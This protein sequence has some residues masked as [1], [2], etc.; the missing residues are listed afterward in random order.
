MPAEL[1]ICKDRAE[2]LERRKNYIGGSDASAVLG[3]NPWKT[4]VELWMEKTGQT[5]PEDISEKPYVKFGTQAEPLMRELFKLDFPELEVFYEENN[6]FLNDKYPWGHYSADGWIK[7]EAG[8]FGIYEGKTTEILRSMQKEKWR[9]KLPDNYYVQLIHGFLITEAEFA[10]L[11][12]RLK[13]V[14]DGMPYIQ[15]RHYKIERSEVQEDI[16][17]W[18]QQ[19]AKFWA[20]VQSKKKPALIL[21]EL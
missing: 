19:G 12:G 8:R 17:Y 21:P 20:C 4:N 14:I 16:D 1:V 13:S 11:K 15:I 10:F 5:T 6:L 9:D 18:A 7:D 2:W 3:L